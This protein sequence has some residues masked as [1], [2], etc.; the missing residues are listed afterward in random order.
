MKHKFKN[1]FPIHARDGFYFQHANIA[2]AQQTG[3]SQTDQQFVM[4]LE[5]YGENS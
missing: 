4:E 3:L 2:G 1:T 5:M